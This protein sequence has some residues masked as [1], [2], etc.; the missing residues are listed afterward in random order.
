ME[1]L[2]DAEVFTILDLKSAYWHIPLKPSDEHKT[3]F[4]VPNGKYQWTVMPFWLTDAAFSLT[5]VMTNILQ[6]FKFLKSFYDDCIVYGKWSG[7]LDLVREVLEKFAEY[8]IHI[9]LNKC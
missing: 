6:D 1:D 5:Y 9:N 4:V 2:N 8:G 3:A 7:D